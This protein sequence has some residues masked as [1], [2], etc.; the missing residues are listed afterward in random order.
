[1]PLGADGA[2]FGFAVGLHPSGFEVAGE[3]VGVDRLGAV[4]V[5]PMSML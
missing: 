4:E 2:G 1:V 5:G 3:V